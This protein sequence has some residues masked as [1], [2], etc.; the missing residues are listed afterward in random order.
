MLEIKIRNW[1][2]V[3]KDY[4]LLHCCCPNENV[5]EIWPIEIDFGGPNAEI[6]R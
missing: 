5:W 1:L 6:S 4:R 2:A 3:F